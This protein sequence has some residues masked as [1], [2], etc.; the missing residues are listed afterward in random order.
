MER[1]IVLLKVPALPGGA[2]T[3]PEA[4]TIILTVKAGGPEALAQ[5][6]A[7]ILREG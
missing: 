1:H 3:L 7:K 4:T 6:A 5:A 2:M